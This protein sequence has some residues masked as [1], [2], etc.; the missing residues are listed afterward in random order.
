MEL[1]LGLVQ[2]FEYGYRY[3]YRYPHLTILLLSLGK[4]EELLM[5]IY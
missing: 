4:D 2:G 3:G 5:G 1:V